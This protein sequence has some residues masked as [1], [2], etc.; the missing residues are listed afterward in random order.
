[1]AAFAAVGR[2]SPSPLENV[3]RVVNK[4]VEFLWYKSYRLAEVTGQSFGLYIATF[5]SLLSVE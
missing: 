5:I 1:M 3:I 2:D 4:V